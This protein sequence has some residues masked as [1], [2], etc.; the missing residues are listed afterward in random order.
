MGCKCVLEVTRGNVTIQA[1]LYQFHNLLMKNTFICFSSITDQERRAKLR[2]IT[3]YCGGLHTAGL[4]EATTHLITEDVFSR[5]YPFA[6]EHK[7]NI[8]KPE[9]LEDFWQMQQNPKYNLRADDAYFDKYKVPIFYKLTITSTGID[10]D[11]KTKLMKLIEDHGGDFSQAFKSNVVKILLM[12]NKDIDSQKHKAATK[13]KIPSIDPKWI[14]DS[15]AAGYALPLDKYRIEKIK[16]IKASTPTKDTSTHNFN[17]ENTMLSDITAIATDLTS[18]N[19]HMTLEETGRTHLSK[20]RDASIRDM[21]LIRKSSR[22]T[23]KPDCTQNKNDTFKKPQPPRATIGAPSNFPQEYETLQPK[24]S[25]SKS[26]SNPPAIEIPP[27]PCVEESSSVTDASDSDLS[28]IPILAGKTVY[29]YGYEDD[30]EIVQLIQ[31][32]E[33]YGGNVVDESYKKKV[34]YIMTPSKKIELVEPDMDYKHLVNDY[35]FEESI[36]AGRCLD[37]NFYHHSI[38]QSHCVSDLLQGETFILSN[39]NVETERPWIKM[40]ITALGGKHKESMKR[41]DDVILLCPTQEGKKYEGAIEWKITVLKADWLYN[42]YKFQKRCDES[43]FLVGNKTAVSKRNKKD[44]TSMIPYSQDSPGVGGTMDLDDDDYIVSR[45]TPVSSSSSAIPKRIAE[46]R[47]TVESPKTPTSTCASPNTSD[48]NEI[49]SLS[50]ICADMP[51]PQRETTIKAIKEAQLENQI[52]PRAARQKELLRTPGMTQNYVIPEDSPM[53]ELP[54]CMRTPV[55]DYSLR[56]NS[57][58]ATK[59]FYKRR[60]DAITQDQYNPISESAKKSMKSNLASPSYE[61]IRDKILGPR[62]KNYATS[63]NTPVSSAVDVEIKS[64]SQTDQ[65]QF[66]SGM[67][68]EAKKFL[69]FDE[70]ENP[71]EKQDDHENE[72][73]SDEN[74]LGKIKSHVSWN[75]NSQSLQNKI[76]QEDVLKNI[77]NKNDTEEEDEEENSYKNQLRGKVDNSPIRIVEVQ[78]SASPENLDSDGESIDFIG[79]QEDNWVFGVSSGKSNQEEVRKNKNN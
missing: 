47:G 35:W 30:F 8:M 73:K 39:Y 46:L 64:K 5:K 67:S 38:F 10:H 61:S 36:R 42:C 75:D 72:S 37:L 41:N 79:S 53:P 45:R 26:I 44:R 48:S 54:N 28:F 1:G 2:K 70:S 76:S 40:I 77:T 16:K 60:F 78:S 65:L 19:S 59:Q 27:A 52:S 7:I 34:D 12:T 33:K 68:Q 9:W 15:I 43:D 32:F 20:V 18:N 69:N 56:P 25:I 13:F 58:P 55:E 23:L 29:L 31:D 62:L 22:S 50:K 11:E 21:P 63:P 4:L 17:F 66:T 24:K 49:L 6:G 51:T 3:T 74:S 57:S 71:A 14:N